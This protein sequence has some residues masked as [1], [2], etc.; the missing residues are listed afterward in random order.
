MKA[1]VGYK[2]IAQHYWCKAPEMLFGSCDP[3][4]LPTRIFDLQQ[5]LGD[6][7]NRR[8]VNPDKRL[9][10]IANPKKQNSNDALDL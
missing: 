4:A 8:I 1:P 3:E 7:L 6:A 9:L 5:K 10:R 2:W